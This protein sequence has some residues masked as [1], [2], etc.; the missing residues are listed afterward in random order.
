MQVFGAPNFSTL[1]SRILIV[2][3]PPPSSHASQQRVLALS[4]EL[5]GE[6]GIVECVPAFNS[7]TFYV[8]E[9]RMPLARLQS[10]IRKRWAILDLKPSRGSLHV[11]PV[12]YDGRDLDELAQHA[13]L[14]AAEVIAR[15]TA[16]EYVVYFLGFQA[17]FAYLGGLDPRLHL[18]RRARPRAR[19]EAGSV[20]IG[21]TMTGVYPFA[22]PGGWSVIGRT[23]RAVFDRALDEPVLLAP[24]DRVRFVP[25]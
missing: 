25:C 5:R 20:A 6:P 21:G 17:G 12:E 3:A 22:S 1:G 4:R 18:P 7:V 9:Q 8:D 23:N 15:H 11:L 13:G 14:T 19:V 10:T 24:G 16:P 2:N